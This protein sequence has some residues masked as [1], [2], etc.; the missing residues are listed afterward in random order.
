LAWTSDLLRIRREEIVP[1][2]PTIA[3]GGT[4]DVAGSVLRVAWPVSDRRLALLANLAAEPAEVGAAAEGTP[5]FESEPGLAGMIQQGSM[6]PWS[7]LWL[8]ASDP[9]A[10][11]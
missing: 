4:A 8:L 5:L 10:T 11:P 3:R 6:P 9:E 1:L 2:L 7:V